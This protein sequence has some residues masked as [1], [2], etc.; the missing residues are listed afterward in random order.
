MTSDKTLYTVWIKVKINAQAINCNKSQLQFT[1][2][3][4]CELKSLKHTHIIHLVKIGVTK[5]GNSGRG[6]QI[7]LCSKLV[8]STLKNTFSICH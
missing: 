2:Q 5:G 3:L 4:F 7:D 6:C 8:I 1:T